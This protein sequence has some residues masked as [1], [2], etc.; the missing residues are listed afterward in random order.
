MQSRVVVSRVHPRVVD[1]RWCGRS[2]LLSDSVC[3]RRCCNRRICCIKIQ[4]IFIHKYSDDDCTATA[5]VG[6]GIHQSTDRCLDIE[7]G[8]RE[9][10]NVILQMRKNVSL[11][12][13]CA[14]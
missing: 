7:G 8:Q 1:S 4:V 9:Y 10:D 14:K 11:L 6:G 13:I 12:T 2:P 5:T 3:Y